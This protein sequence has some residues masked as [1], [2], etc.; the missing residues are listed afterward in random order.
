MDEGL[1]P[2]A[3][4]ANTMHLPSFKQRSQIREEEVYNPVDHDADPVD[5]LYAR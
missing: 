2:L 1:G 4:N 3:D 5:I